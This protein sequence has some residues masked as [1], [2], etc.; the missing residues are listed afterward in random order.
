MLPIVLSHFQTQRFPRNTEAAATITLSPDLGLTTIQATLGPEG[1]FL[2]N[3]EHLD[4][5]GIGEVNESA[6]GCFAIKDGRA[7]KI[8]VFSSTTNRVC[9]L[10]PT[11]G[12]PTMLVAGFTMHRI[13][14]CDPYQDA[15][16]KV[17][18]IAPMRGVVLDTATGLGYTAIEAARTA[19]QVCT[20]EI[21]PGAQEIARQNPWS[22]AL[23]DNA[24][25]TPLLGDSDELVDTFPAGVFDRIIHD[26]PVV[27][28]A[29]HL[30]GAAFYRKLHRVLG[31]RGRLFHYI[32]NPESRSMMNATRGVIE[33]LRAAGFSRVRPCPEA[34][35][36]VAEK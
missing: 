31:A 36:V 7:E 20:I 26:P 13:K 9:S 8:Q 30:Y 15:L 14:N 23:F 11:A 34:F 4:W 35:G 28:L 1:L 27:S 29:G 12:A 6:N 10:M 17:K 5:A 16:A 22:Q 19:A 25:I 18:A 21:D 2:P 32:G 33:R 3:D 24:A